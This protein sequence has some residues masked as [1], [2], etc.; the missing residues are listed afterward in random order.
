[1]TLTVIE[2][3]RESLEERTLKSILEGDYATS[4][5]LMQSLN[6]RASL[7]I[8]SDHIRLTRREV[9][10]LTALTGSDPGNIRTRIQLINFVQAHLVNYPGRTPEEKLLRVMLESF[11][12]DRF[13]CS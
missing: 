5:R 7:K 11:I 8:V 3:D 12:S 6:T 2:G 4:D 1:M 10:Q 9:K 13:D